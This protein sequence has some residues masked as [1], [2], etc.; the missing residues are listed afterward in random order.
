METT[1]EENI[2]NAVNKALTDFSEKLKEC[3]WVMQT[4]IDD[5]DSIFGSFNHSLQENNGDTHTHQ[6]RRG[7]HRE[8]GNVSNGNDFTTEDNNIKPSRSERGCGGLFTQKD[9]VGKTKCKKGLLCPECEADK[10]IDVE[11]KQDLYGS[12]DKK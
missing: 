11:I 1:E 7:T 5:I 12:E 9:D 8:E 6:L 10:E 2:H 3:D 4:Q